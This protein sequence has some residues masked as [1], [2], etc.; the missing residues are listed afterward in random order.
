MP[1]SG[2]QLEDAFRHGQAAI[3]ATFRALTLSHGQAF[4]HAFVT[5][6][7]VGILIA[8]RTRI[9]GSSPAAVESEADRLE[10]AYRGV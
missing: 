10:S 4:A 1:V 3:D 8:A 2:I 9:C 7:R 6:H 5:E